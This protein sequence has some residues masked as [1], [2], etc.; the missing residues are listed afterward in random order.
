MNKYHSNRSYQAGPPRNR[1]AQRGIA[2]IMVLLILSMVIVLSLGMVIALSSQT[3]IG[4]YYRNF[5]GAF[6]AADSGLNIGRQALVNQVGAGF[7]ATFA[8][9]PIANPNALAATVLSSMLSTYGTS[10]SLNTGTAAG[11]WSESFKITNATFSLAV[12]SPTI[13]AYDNS[14]TDC[15]PQPA[16]CPTAYGYTYNYSLTSVGAAQG[17]EQATVTE[18]G[19]ITLN[20]AGAAATSSVSFAYFGGFVDKYPACLGPLVPGTMT[21]PMF[22]NDAWEFMPSQAPWT[23]PYIFTDPVGQHD[24]D[25]Y[26]WGYNFSSCNAS[27]T[28]SY[29]SG[30][31]LVAPTF[32]AGF[33]LNQPTVALP[34]N[35]FSQEWA[36][37][38]GLGTGSQEGS[39]A[40]TSAQLNAGLPAANIPGLSNINGAAYPSSGTS[41]GVF[42]PSSSSSAICGAKA[43]PCIAGG[44]FYVE[45]NANVLLKPTGSSA[46][47]YQITQGS[48]VTTITVDPVANTTVIT[49]GTT[50]ETLNG[51]PENL[52]TGQP[53]AM[54]YVDGSV[55]SLTGPGEGQGAIQDNAMITITAKGDVTATGDVLYKTEPVTYTQ[56]QVVAGSSPACCV[57]LPMD[58]LI[59]SRENMTQVLGI[60]TA[61]GNFNLNTTQP[62]NN[63]QVD[64]SI[65]TISAGGCGAFY[66]TGGYINTFNNV[67]GQIQNC[68]VGANIS[69]ENIWFD[70]RFTAV[71]GFAP[72]W[73]PSTAIKQGGPSPDNVTTSVYRVQWLNTSSM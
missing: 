67:G 8:E 4:G 36:V 26:Y 54:V 9:P 14:A 56:D 2:L 59:P 68:I 64:G 48:T 70:R 53:S 17:S 40:P 21:G 57:G 27:A 35:Q 39:A 49:S 1:A 63:I 47:V 33:N 69:T 73:F 16:P 23:A 72:P 29:G 12:G 25:A 37:L 45:G 15:S 19:S 31:S 20:V 61:T 60:F 62:D 41:T 43:T 30:S 6:Y 28:T 24:A 22:T 18:N 5:R 34:T 38:D 65:A 7:P 46:Q 51:V 42:F 10:T 13:T 44:G 52:I 58:S 11:S 50:T 3:F 71:P 66:D 32:Q 55:T